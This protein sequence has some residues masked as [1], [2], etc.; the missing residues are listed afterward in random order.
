MS[1]LAQDLFYAA[2]LLKKQP[3]VT[4]IMVISLALGIGVRALLLS[5]ST[6]ARSNSEGSFF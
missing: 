5:V 6:R 2:R 1:V 3:G 4:A